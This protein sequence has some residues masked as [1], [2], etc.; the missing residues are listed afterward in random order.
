MPERILALAT[1]MSALTTEKVDRIQVVTKATKILALNAMIEAQ[2]A[3]AAG[4]GFGVVAEEVKSISSQIMA[5]ADEVKTMFAEEVRNLHTTANLARG[6]R[7]SDLAGYAVEL[8]D[9]NLYERSCDVRW[10]ATDSAVVEACAT[11]SDLAAAHASQRLGVI[12]DSYTVYLDLWVADRQGRVIANGRPSRY[13]VQGQSV[14]EEP[15]FRDA[16][17]TPSGEHYA[18]ADIAASRPLGNRAVATYATAIREGGTVDGRAIG[19]LGIFFDWEPQAQA[20]VT[21][22]QLADAEKA[23][24]RVM[25]V[26]SRHQVIA[27]SD[28]QGLLRERFPLRADGQPAGA[29]QQ[30]DGTLVGFRLTPGYETYRGLGWYGV[31]AQRPAAN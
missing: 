22:P 2:R 15:W 8:V 7:L 25:L 13:Q 3:G 12:L 4:R 5:I 16:L 21:A 1:R 6:A 9:R 19:V 11:P 18:V 24:T 26:D 14:A 10:W 28:G 27:S 31:I 29:Y 17:A 20:I 23:R 30:P